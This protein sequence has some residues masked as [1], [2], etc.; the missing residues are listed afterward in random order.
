[1]N[2]LIA[3]NDSVTLRHASL[4]LEHI[5]AASS[6]G[7]K[8]NSDSWDVLPSC[9]YPALNLAMVYYHQ[10]QFKESSQLLWKLF[11]AASSS[12]PQFAVQVSFL[13]LDTLLR[14]WESADIFIL[15]SDSRRK[16]FASM[17]DLVFAHVYRYI[18]GA[19]GSSNTNL[20]SNT[21]THLV[22]E[23]ILLKLKVYQ[24]K[25]AMLV[26]SSFGSSFTSLLSDIS[27]CLQ[28]VDGISETTD[29][30]SARRPLSS[31]I[32][33]VSRG[34]CEAFPMSSAEYHYLLFMQ[35]CTWTL[36]LLFFWLSIFLIF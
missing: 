4:Q 11:R 31:S 1:M 28:P 8:F 23:M 17:T 21:I 9:L 15:T 36:L 26:G 27:R 2:N 20:R 24:C 3:A 6:V 10:S 5:L 35:V 22:S 30:L 13:L 34:I 32:L 25:V 29:L 12:N 14:C 18:S 33:A 7:N 16:R 19:N